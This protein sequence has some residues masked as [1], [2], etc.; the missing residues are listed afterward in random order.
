MLQAPESREVSLG[1]GV[2]IE[3][4]H[5]GIAAK[6]ELGEDEEVDLALRAGAGD[7]ARRAD[8]R[9]GEIQHL[10]EVAFEIADHRI[11]LGQADQHLRLRENGLPRAAR[12]AESIMECC[13]YDG[14]IVH[15]AAWQRQS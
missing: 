8:R 4:I 11:N 15:S 5:G 13:G 3:Q 12:I 6:G 14:G 10:G 7:R 9:R 1:E 2:L